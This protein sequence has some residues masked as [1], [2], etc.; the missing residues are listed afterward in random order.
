MSALIDIWTSES[1]K[2]R[3]KNRS[4]SPS[5]SLSPA[6]AE[7]KSKSS[8]SS[9]SILA[10]LL[11]FKTGSESIRRIYICFFLFCHNTKNMS[12]LVDIWT[13]ESA[14]LREK[15]QSMSPSVSSSPAS[16]ESKSKSSKSSPPILARLLQFK[17][18]PKVAYS[19]AT[20]SIIMDCISA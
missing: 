14:K 8:E 17:S 9:P 5:V 15:S 1:A 2:L 10:R 6:S 20:I 19:E 7:S 4:I 18:G 11:R 13:S 16:A 3:E 12:A